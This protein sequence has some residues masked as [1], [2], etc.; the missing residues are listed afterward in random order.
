MSG[1]PARGA[2]RGVLRERAMAT[3][4]GNLFRNRWLRWGLI[5]GFWTLLG[6]FETC[7]TYNLCQLLRKNIPTDLIVLR[8]LTKWYL[9]GIIA[10]TLFDLARRFPITPEQWPVNL[11]IQVVAACAF[12]LLRV[13]LNVPVAQVLRSEYEFE[14][15]SWEWFAIY[16]ADSFLPFVLICAFIVGLGHALAYYR[17]LQDRELREA[18]LQAQ[19]AQAQ[20]QLLKMQLHPHFLFN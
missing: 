20:L 15:T 12:A 18:A 8:S 5:F 9:W 11:T 7:Q 3:R 16:F 17:K 4:P 1:P 2:G 6:L 14:R 10:P 13:A 19:L